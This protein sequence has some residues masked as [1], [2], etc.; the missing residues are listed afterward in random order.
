MQKRTALGVLVGGFLLLVLAAPAAAQAKVDF[1]A[2]Y[3]YLNFLEEGSDSV[4]AG[5]GTSIAVGNAWIKAVGDV[6]G[7]YKNGVSLYTF[8]GGAEFSTTG[9]RVIAFGRILAGA[10]VGFE[11]GDIG[12]IFVLTP[13]A[14]VKLMA[15][16]RVGVQVSVGFP[17]FMDSGA[18]QTGMRV[19]AGFVI[20]K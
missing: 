3:Q 5:F 8:Q 9:K 6:G 12:S 1:S 15:N 13:E 10:A 16:D 2:G 20:R 4:P 14:G 18:H 7:H 11:D 19:F 17:I